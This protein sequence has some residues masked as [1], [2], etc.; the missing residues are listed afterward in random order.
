MLGV[1]DVDC[2]GSYRGNVSRE[3]GTRDHCCKSLRSTSTEFQHPVLRRAFLFAARHYGD[4][5]NG[6]NTEPGLFVHSKEKDRW[7]QIT[8]ISTTD[9]RFGKST[10]EDPDAMK[11]LRAAS[12][13][14][15]FTQFAQR[16]YVDQPLRTSGSIVFPDR[17]RYESPGGRYELGY[18]SSW[19]IPSAETVLY[20][21]RQD[22]IETFARPY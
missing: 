22:L 17:I 15:D 16:Q 4:S 11:K 1:S 7:I 3:R 19:G 6:G 13:V 20:V 14:W 9:G 5:R 12:V 8:A 18:L 21:R 10:S 2:D